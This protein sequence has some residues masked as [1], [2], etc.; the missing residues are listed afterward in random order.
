LTSRGLPELKALN[1]EK[2]IVDWA[3]GFFADPAS[4][5]SAE[6]STPVPYVFGQAPGWL[7][8]IGYDTRTRAGDYLGYRR[9]AFGFGTAT[10]FPPLGRGNNAVRNEVCDALPLSWRPFPALERLGRAERR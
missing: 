4:L 6:I 2:Q 7:V 1:Y 5:R 8:C 10:F 9:L 3:A